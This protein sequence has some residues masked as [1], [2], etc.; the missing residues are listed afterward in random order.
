M[1]KFEVEKRNVNLEVQAT[2]IDVNKEKEVPQAAAYAFTTG[3]RLLS[4]EALTAQGQGKLNLTLNGST[5]SVRVIVG[6]DVDMEDIK[7][8]ELLR[9]GAKDQIVRIKPNITQTKLDFQI[10]PTDWLCWLRSLYIVKGTLEKR[11]LIDGTTIDLPVCNATV[12]VYEVDPFPIII[13]RIPDTLIEKFRNI[14]LNPINP[15]IPPEQFSLPRP[16]VNANQELASTIAKTDRFA[17]VQALAK[18]TNTAQFRQVILDYTPIL[19]PIFCFYLP[20]TKKRVATVKTD[21]CGRF[22]AFFFNGCNNPDRPDLY[23]IAKQKIWPFFPEFTI[24]EPKPV[25]CHTHWN[26]QS[27]TEVKLYT[28]SPWVKTCDP[29]PPVI[30]PNDWVLMMAIGNRSMNTIHGTSTDLLPGT[31]S[32]NKGL[33]EHGAPFGGILRFRLEFDPDLMDNLGIHYY[34]MSFRKGNTG[35]FIPMSEAIYRH[36]TKEVDSELVIEPLKLG[37]FYLAGK[38][39]E[40]FFKIPK[41]PNDAIQWS[42]PNV[43]EDT[44]NA[45]WNTYNLGSKPHADYDK[46]EAWDGAGKYQVKLELFDNNGDLIDIDTMGIQYRVPDVDD[47]T[48]T[49]TTDNASTLNLVSIAN[50]DTLK[51]FNMTVH[52]DN[53]KCRAQV[54]APILSGTPAGSNCGVMDYDPDNKGASVQLPF[55]AIH[56]NGF[57]TYSF[58]IL[59]GDTNV[60]PPPPPVVGPNTLLQ[61]GTVPSSP[62]SLSVAYMLD[63]CT[64]AGF[65]EEVKCYAM[66]TDGWNSRLRNLDDEKD[67]AFV[68]APKS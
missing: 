37:P 57:A 62:E 3:G 45:K 2:L 25:S 1:T 44:A 42:F 26:Y 8:D 52:V 66:A 10:V 17:E 68:L 67:R 55:S 24:Y 35:T 11:Q 20:V 13:P 43:V 40:P 63:G 18:R 49:I 53:S 15:P 28:T 9:R 58:K 59:R 46:G 19:R 39:D 61:T 41:L 31:N 65:L 50:G 23:F 27:G 5:K 29:C 6:P 36:Y 22:T 30:A 4:K 48:S 51:S 21:D 64:V 14:I 33:T 12:E 56:P 34:R 38:A 47:L 7:I 54:D 32:T 60:P 16:Q